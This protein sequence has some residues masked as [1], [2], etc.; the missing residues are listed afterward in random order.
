MPTIRKRRQKYQ[1]QVRH[2]G[3]ISVS[4]TFTTLKDAKA[5]AHQLE[6][7]ID[8]RDL[9]ADPKVL[10]TTTLGELVARY[11]D[12]VSPRKRTAK[13][14]RIVL[15]AFLLHPICRRRLSEITRAD[16]IAYRDERLKA[17]KSS[18]LKRSLVPLHNLYELARTEWGLPI[19]E[20]PVSNLNL[21][22]SDQRRERRLAEGELEKLEVAVRSCRNPL[23][24]PLV[25]LALATSLRRSE[26]LAIRWDDIDWVQ[27][28]LLIRH[29]KNGQSRILPLTNAAIELLQGVKK[30]GD[31]VFPI[32]ANA[33]RLAW[34]KLRKRAGINDL[35][36][37]DLRHE[38]VSKFFEAGL[39]VPEVALMSG[40]RDIRMLLRY[41]HAMRQR[42]LEKLDVE[43]AH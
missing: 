3:L 23:M 29:S 10:Q 31:H 22:G 14:E 28:T 16:F 36:F 15:G 34:E 7:Q 37:H 32:S 12:T 33:V 35:H 6:V 30:A 5:W 41:S 4:R 11:R 20:N 24:Q 43:K 42:V 17:I 9:P 26:L 8:R 40:H 18:S 25:R 38:A 27:R 13:A 39:T 2:R 1:V 21:N 19:K